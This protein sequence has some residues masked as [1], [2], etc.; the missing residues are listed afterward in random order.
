MFDSFITNCFKSKAI[1]F[2]K[3]RNA[4]KYN[5]MASEM[6][7]MCVEPTKTVLI[8]DSDPDI[9]SFCVLLRVVSKFLGMWVCR[10]LLSSN[11]P[12][13]SCCN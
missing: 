7:N 3:H 1:N 4:H 5:T 2:T 13:L 12:A 11:I 9:I 10:L 6:M 8:N